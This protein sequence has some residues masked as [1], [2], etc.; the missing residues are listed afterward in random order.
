MKVKVVVFGLQERANN[1]E[2]LKVESFIPDGLTLI[3]P[4]R[5]GTHFWSLFQRFLEYFLFSASCDHKF[6]PFEKYTLAKLLHKDDNRV[7]RKK[8]ECSLKKLFI[9]PYHVLYNILR[10]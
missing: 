8:L 1:Y 9:F 2:S 7:M 4:T 6:L 3:C 5:E 10:G